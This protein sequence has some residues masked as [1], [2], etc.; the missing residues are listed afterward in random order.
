MEQKKPFQSFQEFWPFYLKEHSNRLNRRLH[1]LGTLI[2]TC[3]FIYSASTQNWT[4]L[5]ALPVF[6]YAFAWVGH[7]VIERNRPATFRHPLW[8]LMGDFKMFYLILTRQ[9]K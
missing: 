3:L 8:S 4:L 9:L 1:F 2:V 6:G 7:L 5:W